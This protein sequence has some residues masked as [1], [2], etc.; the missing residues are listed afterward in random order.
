MLGINVHRSKITSLKVPSWAGHDW[1]EHKFER[2]LE[3]YLMS[4]AGTAFGK[5]DVPKNVIYDA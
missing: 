2:V 5:L 1:F 4:C 3:N